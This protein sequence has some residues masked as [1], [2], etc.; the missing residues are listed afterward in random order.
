MRIAYVK[1]FLLLA[2]AGAI[3]GVVSVEAVAQSAT[4]FSRNRYPTAQRKNCIT[5]VEREVEK[6]PPGAPIELGPPIEPMRQPCDVTYGSLWAG[7]ERDWL[8]SSGAKG[9]RSV[10]RDLGAYKWTDDF[11]VPVVAALPKLKP[12]EV[13]TVTVDVSGADGADAPGV[14]STRPK[15]DGKPKIDPK[16]VK[17]VIGHMYVIHVVD[18][19]QDFYALF[20][21]DQ[22]LHG[23]SCVVSWKLIDAPSSAN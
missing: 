2:V 8:E 18:D 17:A 21:V 4:L 9:N 6:R 1:A 22:L 12:G 5:F 20:R 15:H 23:D 13:R 10:I 14:R 19:A 11:V 16:F 7:G 3:V